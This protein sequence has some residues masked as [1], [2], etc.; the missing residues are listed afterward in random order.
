M[1]NI[2][3]PISLF[4]I[5]STVAFVIAGCAV[6]TTTPDQES[7]GSAEE[8]VSCH[9]GG[10]SSV[11]RSQI[12]ARGK[13]WY[14]QHVQYSQHACHANAYGSYR[15]DCSG[16]V[17]M[18]WALSSSYT[19]STLSNV[20]K[21]LGSKNE[22]QPGDILLNKASHVVLFEKWANSAHTKYWAYEE[23]NPRTDMAHHVIPYPY[24]SGYG[25]FVPY[26]Y[27]H[28][29]TTHAASAG[30]GITESAGTGITESTGTEEILGDPP[31][32]ED[33]GAPAGDVG[34]DGAPDTTGA[35]QSSSQ[36]E[37]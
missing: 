28:I 18:A 27:N 7:T 9:A 3:R 34:E 25:T 31:V 30:T 16:F 21:K 22:L 13:S 12:L 33:P 10:K 6:Q 5:P 14:D 2:F 1:K 4:V 17:S 36:E 20:S 11:T 35:A 24:Y 23:T 29:A 37:N 32:D 19:T 26:R 15:T 8:A